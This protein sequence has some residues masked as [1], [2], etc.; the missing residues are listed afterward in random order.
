MQHTFDKIPKLH[1]NRVVEA[2]LIELGIDGRLI[3]LIKVI[4]VALNRHLAQ[5]HKHH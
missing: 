4:E 3:Q 1:R 2:Q 5:Q